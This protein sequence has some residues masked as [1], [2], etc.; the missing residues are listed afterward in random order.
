MIEKDFSNKHPYINQFIGLIGFLV[1]VVAVVEIIKTLTKQFLEL[2]LYTS[3][4]DAVVMVA[5]VTG[6]VS[7]F[8][9]VISKWAENKQRKREYLSKKREKPYTDFI[10]MV[11]KLKDKSQE[12][13]EEEMN[14]DITNFSEQ[15]TLWGSNNVVKK[16]VKFRKDKENNLVLLE[17]IMFE[18]RK[19][20]GYKKLKK[21]DLL[22]FFVNDVDKLF[23][24]Q[25]NKV[26]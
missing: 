24:Q 19:D 7:F 22:S 5:L 20:I 23:D 1:L 25:I 11:Y 26:E 2:I 15:L 3:Q 12:Y 9:V 14:F 16:W 17:E 4:L 21:G 8:T 6:S 18:M 10:A 13:T